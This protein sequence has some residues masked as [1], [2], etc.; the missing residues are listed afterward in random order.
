MATVTRTKR[1]VMVTVYNKGRQGLWEV[2]EQGKRVIDA[3][4]ETA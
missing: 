3:V 2:S 1:S 4:K